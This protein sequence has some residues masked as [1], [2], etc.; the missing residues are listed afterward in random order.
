MYENVLPRS[1]PEAQGLRSSGISKF[2]DA[3]ESNHQEIHSFMLL[4]N[5]SVV[6]EAWWSPYARD[7][8]HMMFSLS[9]SFTATAV[10]MAVD[11]G[12]FSLDDAVISFFPDEAPREVSDY[13]AN[14]RVKH[15]LSMSTGHD[16]KPFP[17]MY[18]QK[19][20]NWAKGFFEV[21]LLHEPGTHFLY[22]TGASYMLSEI[23]QRK[24]GLKLMDFLT[25]RLFEP[26]GIECASW[27][28]SPEGVSLGGI[29]L[30]IKT[31]DIARF[32]QLYLQKGLWQGQQVLSKAWVEEATKAHVSNGDNPKSDWAQGY[33]YQFW[34]CQHGF[35]RGDGSFGQFCFVLEKYNAVLAMTAAAKDMQV[36][37]NTVWDSLVPA[38][39]A[40]PLPED[41]NAHEKLLA[42]LSSLHH[43][44]IQGQAMSRTAVKFSGKS[45]LAEANALGI[46]RLSLE[47]SESESRVTLKTKDGEQRITVGYGHWANGKASIFP[48]IWLSGL[49]NFLASGAWLDEN[50][51]MMLLRLYETPYIF[52]M[53]YQFEDEALTITMQINVSLSST[54]PQTIHA[55][56]SS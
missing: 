10:G 34:R 16:V 1:S 52:T 49:Q 35:Y 55:R 6:A 56:L 23:V 51:Y 3:L 33:G 44:P 38:F 46:E 25:P 20:S 30:S 47:F 26:L 8:P 11:E 43:A 4:R 7:I 29:G 15:L 39:E 42:R 22:N 19:D 28:Q 54:E 18:E 32:G 27:M 41:K 45:Y 31:E 36:V 2:L 50:R 17:T 40:S 48:E 12:F 53:S 21:P 14:L 13:W 5:G 24:T 37:M 9:K